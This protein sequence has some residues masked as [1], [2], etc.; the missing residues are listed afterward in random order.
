VL[1]V[2][3]SWSGSARAADPAPLPSPSDQAAQHYQRGNAA[4]EQKKWPEAEEAYLKAWQLS[5]TFD[6]AANLGLV[7]LRLGKMRQAAEYLAYSLRNAPP[8]SK[9]AQREATQRFLDEA[10]AKIGVVRL[11]LNVSGARVSVNGHPAV[12]DSPPYEVFADPGAATIEA[13]SDGYEDTRTTVQVKA[14]ST[15]ELNLTLVEV[16][17]ASRSAVPGIILGGAGVALLGAGIG[18]IVDA[19]GKTDSSNDLAKSIRDAGHSCVANASNFDAR[20]TT[21]EETSS[22]GSMHDRV[23]IG[24]MIGGG[25]L[26]AAAGAYFLWPASKAADTHA[27][28]STT[29]MPLVSATGAGLVWSGAF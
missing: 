25:A 11:R 15:Q 12:L 7:E 14:G 6:V 20:C 17:P 2:A 19:K 1:G 21:L 10:K 29:V 13:K 28:R 4:F 16:K 18:L 27:A 26:A 3:L 24:L 9:P 23:G 5:R 22:A 8:S